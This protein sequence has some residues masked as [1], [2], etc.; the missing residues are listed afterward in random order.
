MR[1]GITYIQDAFV[2]DINFPIWKSTYSE[3]D[4]STYPRGKKQILCDNK[5]AGLC[6]GWSISNSWQKNVD[7]ISNC[8]GEF[9]HL[10]LRARSVKLVVDG[11]L[12]T[13]TAFMKEEYKNGGTYAYVVLIPADTEL[14]SKSKRGFSNF[15]KEEMKEI[16]SYIDKLHLQ[17]KIYYSW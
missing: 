15:K 7:Y 1:Q 5:K 12:E 10:K 16:I 13:Q 2:R 9:P 14:E 11:V 4:I 17:V 8:S 6:L 3:S